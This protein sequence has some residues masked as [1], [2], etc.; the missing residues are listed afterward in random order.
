[1]EMVYVL[2]YGDTPMEDKVANF[3]HMVQKEEGMEK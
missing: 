3:M 1:M 2:Y